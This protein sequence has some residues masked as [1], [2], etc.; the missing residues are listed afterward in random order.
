MV[1]R[2]TYLKIVTM[3][4][5]IIMAMVFDNNDDGNSNNWVSALESESKVSKTGLGTRA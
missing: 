2:I 3:V 5:K 1:I 4:T